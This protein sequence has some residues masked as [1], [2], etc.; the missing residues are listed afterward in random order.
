MSGF[1][2]RVNHTAM[3]HAAMIAMARRGLVHPAVAYGAVAVVSAILFVPYVLAGGWLGDDW[4]TEATA[5]F[6]GMG[7]VVHALI[8]A[9][10]TRPVQDVY[11]GLVHVVLG[12]HPHLQV[13]LAATL[14]MVMSLLV[15]SVL[16]KL[17][18]DLLTSFSA[19]LLTLLF[20]FSDSTWLWSTGGA[21]TLCVVLWLTGLLAALKGLRQQPGG[22]PW[23]ALAVMLYVASLL[24]YELVLPVIVMSGLIYFAQAPRRVA[25]RRWAADVV[26]VCL[27]VA[28]DLYVG[29]RHHTLGLGGALHHVRLIAGQARMLLARSFVPFGSVS[30]IAILAAWFALLVA[31]CVVRGTSPDRYIRTETGRWLKLTTAGTLIAVGGWG[32]LAPAK[33]WYE[34]LSQGIGNRINILAG[35]GV[36]LVV[37][38]GL[39]LACSLIVS[40]WKRAPAWVAPGFA[41]IA[42]AVVAVG[43]GRLTV[44]D[45]AGYERAA[46]EESNVLAAIHSIRPP[47]Q[48]GSTLIV[49]GSPLQAAPGV[50]VFATAWD[51]GS[52]VELL[53]DDPSVT[54][55]PLPGANVWD[56]GLV[57]VGCHEHRVTISGIGVGVAFPPARSA[58]RYGRTQVFDVRGRWRA[59]IDDIATCRRIA[60]RL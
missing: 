41:L 54:A 4:W 17:G 47:P 6:S 22:Q 20:P 60:Q 49:A 10:P 15:L 27:V 16:R 57:R 19:A 33:L 23:H 48:N 24:T 9:E 3:N 44:R 14:S 42:V 45:R 55:W 58:G 52:A 5:H 11:L 21:I 39:S 32:V 26:A 29:N 46:A 18:F 34:P 56:F 35:I 7:G 28:L 36:V 1:S 13:A 53:E 8:R 37:V 30:D 50:P 43:Y 12:G 2:D 25:R 38:A 51:L 59:S 40:A 31:A